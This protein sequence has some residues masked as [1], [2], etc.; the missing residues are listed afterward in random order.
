M[1]PR[2]TKLAVLV[3]ILCGHV[4]ARAEDI[5]LFVGP[6]GNTTR[7]NVL[8]VIDNTANWNQAFETEIEALQLVFENMSAIDGSARFNVGIMLATETG[9]PN[10]NTSGGYVRAAIR[11][12]TRDTGKLYSDMIGNFHKLNDKGNAGYSAMQMVEAYRYFSSGVPYAG[13]G[14]VKT[15]FA[16]N[17]CADCN[18]TAVQ[19]LANAK[20]WALAGNALPGK[21]S[22]PY[23][24]AIDANGCAKN[25]IIYISNGPNQQSASTDSSANA[26]LAAAIAEAGVGSAATITISPTGSQSNPSDEWAKFMK[27]SVLAV[28]TY[29]LDVNPPA[30]GQGPGWTAL[31]QSMAKVSNGAYA[32]VDSSGGAEG[33][34]EKINSYLS[35]IQAVNSVF[36]SVSLPVSVNTQG[37]YLNQVYVGMFRPDSNANPRWIGNLKQYRIGLSSV[38]TLR[39]QDASSPAPLNAINPNTGFIDECVRSFWS[40][41]S[42]YWGFLPQGGCI[43][44][45]A[46]AT[47]LNLISDIPDGNVVEKGAHAQ[48]LR[49]LTARALKTCS[50]VFLSCT[51]NTDFSTNNG[52]ITESLLGAGSSTERDQLIRWAYGIDVDDENANG[53]R[54]DMRASIHGDVVHSRP[55]AINFGSAAAPSVVVFYGGN[56]GVLR[57]VNGNRTADISG[58]PAGGELWGFMPPEYF[59]H[60]KRQRDNTQKNNFPNV[61]VPPTSLQPAPKSYGMDGPVTAYKDSSNTWI[62]ATMRRGG[63]VLYSF[64]V[65]PANPADITLKWKKGCAGNFSAP[66]VASDANCTSGY[67]DAWA[68]LGQTWAAPQAFKAKAE[69]EP[70]LIM[71]GGYDTCEDSHPNVC[72]SPKG[73]A[74]FVLEA[75]TGNL[76]RVFTTDRSVVADVVIVPDSTGH[77]SIAY[78]VDLGGNIYRISI[79]SKAIGDWAM[80]KVASL[81]CAGAVG[82]THNRKFMFAPDVASDGSGGYFLLLGSGDRE[83]PLLYSNPVSN[84][85]FMVKDK[86]EDSTWLSSEAGNCGSAVICKDSLLG[87]FPGPT[88]SAAMLAAKKGWFLPLESSEQVVTSAI[89]IFGTVT[90]STHQPTLPDPDKCTSNLG[91]AR[92]YNI[93]YLDASPVKKDRFEILPPDIGLPPS[94]VAGLVTLDNGQT[95]PFCIGCSPASPLEAEQPPVPTSSFPTQPKRRVY[96]YIDSAESP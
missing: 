40:S 55:V 54:T 41:A 70:L 80:T 31:L 75:N 39:L 34:A 67:S 46:A 52:A 37:T 21:Q 93:F 68:A 17:T 26:A 24:S 53:S 45:T 86:P 28:T 36:A 9:S 19:K 84:Y 5:D 11:P 32:A 57:A 10:N 8:F 7:P 78:A 77:A 22:S 66:G 3:L 59:G 1:N 23:Q 65:N 91:T 60:I 92:V 49:A 56:D 88:P 95:V 33:I 72:S 94:P 16:L 38:S 12:I 14:K 6:T 25:F 30:S 29:T 64:N 61:T 42:T 63:R 15:D 50:P 87:T 89:T 73:S 47:Q 83:K 4:C 90:F 74:I 48:R 58:V 27:Q 71:G 82:C 69:T 18:L 96:W 44:A 35:Q 2:Y 51:A 79:G 13:N 20:V 85:F 43:G 81:G 62:Y 76:L